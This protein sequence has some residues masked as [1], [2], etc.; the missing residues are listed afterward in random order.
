MPNEH[1]KKIS[2]MFNMMG[3]IKPPAMDHSV[4]DLLNP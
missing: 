3:G 1:H 2:D 4:M